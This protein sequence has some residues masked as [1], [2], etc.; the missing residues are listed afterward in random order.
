MYFADTS[1][2]G[3]IQLIPLSL[4]FVNDLIVAC[5]DGMD[6]QECKQNC[7]DNC[8]NNT[9]NVLSGLCVFG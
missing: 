9:C 1:V 4:C 6:G 3:G 5:V 8:Y 2:V 7:S